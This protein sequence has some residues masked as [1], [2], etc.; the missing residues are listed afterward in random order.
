M[1]TERIT[2]MTMREDVRIAQL[3]SSLLT[4]YLGARILEMV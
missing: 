1:R 2:D 4:T 3:M